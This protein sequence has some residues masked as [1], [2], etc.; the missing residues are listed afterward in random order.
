MSK[1]YHNAPLYCWN[2]CYVFSFKLLGANLVPACDPNPFGLFGGLNSSLTIPYHQI[3][4]TNAYLPSIYMNFA[5][6]ILDCKLV[7]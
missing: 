1:I 5:G 6:P 2:L 4:R 3:D 7:P